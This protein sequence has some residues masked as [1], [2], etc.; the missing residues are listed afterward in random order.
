MLP[1]GGDFKFD[2]HNFNIFYTYNL[3]FS[4]LSYDIASHQFYRVFI[5]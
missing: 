2:Q 1:E 4:I 3:N 5:I